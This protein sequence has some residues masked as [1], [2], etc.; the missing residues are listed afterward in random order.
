M[1]TNKPVKKI[2]LQELLEVCREILDRVLLEKDATPFL[3]LNE[4]LT[5]S[6]EYLSIIRKPI[7]FERV[8][9][10]ISISL[11]EPKEELLFFLSCSIHYLTLCRSSLQFMHCSARRNSPRMYTRHLPSL[12]LISD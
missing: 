1:V 4:E 6:Q 12:L 3:R 10:S 11:F 2:P 7:D 9:V 5:S 8:K